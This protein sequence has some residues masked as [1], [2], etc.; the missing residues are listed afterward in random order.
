MSDNPKYAIAADIGGSHIVSAAINL[1]EKQIL[2]E[3]RSHHR[4]DSKASADEIMSSWSIALNETLSRIDTE[5]LA[6]FG[7]ALPGAFNYQEG[8]GKYEGSN[9]KFQ[10]LYNVHIESALRPHLQL[11]RPVAFR[12][13]NDAT[14]FAVGEA[15][16]G[17]ASDATKVIAIT[18]GTGLGSAFIE[19]GLPI[20]HRQDVPKEGCLWHLPFRDDIADAY[21]SARWFSNAFPDH[22]Q[23]DIKDVKSLAEAAR[24]NSDYQEIFDAFGA[25]MVEL[26]IPWLAKF[27]AEVIVFG[28]NITGAFDLFSPSLQS[29]LASYGL[30]THLE[31]SKLMEDAALFGSARLLD[32]AFWI[33]IKDDL[34]TL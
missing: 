10:S 25:N 20:V 17:S 14:S 18:L 4:V 12:F 5:Q 22:F 9:E 7:F 2:S 32:D 16:V 3:S 13:L 21:F 31:V 19:K 6:G 26:L 29:G 8:I 24:E 33:Q 27:P 15:W 11:D 34:P 1:D 30:D 23:G 28:G